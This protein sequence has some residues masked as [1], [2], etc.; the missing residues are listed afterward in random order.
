MTK[1]SRMCVAMAGLF[2]F[3]APAAAQSFDAEI[4]CGGIFNGGD[5]VPYSL[6]FEEQANQVHVIDITVTLTGPGVNKNI[7][8]RMFTLNPNQ[9]KTVNKSIVLKANAPNGNYQLRITADDGS[10]SPT[11]TCSFNVN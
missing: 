4:D 5:T 6:R 2:A 1:L 9:D 11:D 10:I 7:V 8:T 3:A